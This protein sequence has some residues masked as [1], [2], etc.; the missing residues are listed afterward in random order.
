MLSAPNDDL[1]A[2]GMSLLIPT[3]SWMHANPISALF[4]SIGPTALIRRR[5][6]IE[7]LPESGHAA[8]LLQ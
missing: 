6:G 4:L 3:D 5:K 2:S 1:H 8:K 7:D